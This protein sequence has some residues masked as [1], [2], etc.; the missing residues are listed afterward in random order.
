MYAHGVHH[1]SKDSVMRDIIENVGPCTLKPKNDFF[2]SLVQS[3]MYQQLSLKAAGTI[4][5]RFLKL[6][7]TLNPKNVL[8]LTAAQMRKAGVSKQKQTYLKDLAKH[9]DK[10]LLTLHKFE[11]W[12]DQEIIKHLTQIKGIGKWTAEMFLIFS[13]NRLDV[14]PTDDL[15]LQRAIMVNYKLKK[16][17]SLKKMNELAKKWMPYRTIATWYLWRSLEGKNSDWD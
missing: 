2:E 8:K 9:F 14:F 16:Y 7:K 11:H 15:G 1:L 3:I 6:V 4:Y 13:L 17:P 12:S 5:D 10:K